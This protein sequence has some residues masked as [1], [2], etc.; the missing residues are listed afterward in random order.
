MVRPVLAQQAKILGAIDES[1]SGKD[2]AAEFVSDVDD[3]FE[4]VESA[5]QDDHS[6]IDEIAAGSPV[7]NLVN[8]M[9]QRAV[10][11]GASDI[12]IEPSRTKSRIRYR[13]DG[14]LYEY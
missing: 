11:D 7:I 2:F 9:I 6:T 12:H 14:V 3:D 13:I 10:R 4:V 5:L 1:L 8:A